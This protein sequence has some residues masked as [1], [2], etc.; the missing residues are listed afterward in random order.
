M[1]EAVVDI[2]TDGINATKI[3]CIVA[4]CYKTNKVESW[5]GQECKDFGVWSN[6][7]DTFKLGVRPL[8][9][10]RETSMTFQSTLQ[11][12]WNIVNVIQK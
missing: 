4:R 3:Y 12:C 5:V 7:I 6:Q 10:R 2:E 8:A 1:V 9:L 11:R